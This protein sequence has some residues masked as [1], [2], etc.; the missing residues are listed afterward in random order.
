MNSHFF[1]EIKKAMR[2]L[3]LTLTLAINTILVEAASFESRHF[4]VEVLAPGVFAVINKDAG[5]AICNSGIVDL[6]E[7]TLVF[8]CFIS[9]DAARDLKQVA[10][11]L[12]GNPVNYVVNSHYHNDHIRGNQVFAG[13]RILATKATFDL[14]QTKDPEELES[15]KASIDKRIELFEEKL[16]NAL[17]DHQKQEC[18]MVLDYFRAIKESFG[19]YQMTLPDS[20]ISDSI[21]IEGSE[22][23]IVLLSKGPGH[24]A[25]DLVM[26]LPKEKILF[27]ADLVFIGIH[28]W[29]G[30]GSVPNW[31]N[32]LKSLHDLKPAVVVPGHGTVGTSS[33]IDT[34]IAYLNKSSEI[35]DDAIKKGKKAEE[36]AASPIPES[37]RQWWLSHF[38][39]QNLMGLYEARML[40]H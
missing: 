15:E 18:S 34:M 37:F 40:K 11:E 22:R 12:T 6:G 3:M 21:C 31:I 39:A 8:D 23:R 16:K 38:F 27:T 17:N 2:L 24:T 28:P 20:I 19:D 7:E 30:D 29:L 4:T 10:E 26:W 33:D 14:I 9:P 25:D 35:V 32:Y 1:N 36:I 5:H 13:A